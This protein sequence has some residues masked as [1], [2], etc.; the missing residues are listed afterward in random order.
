MTPDGRRKPLQDVRHNSTDLLAYEIVAFRRMQ[1][2]A[3][4]WQVPAISLTAQSF[5]LTTVFG[6]TSEV[7]RVVTGL[8]SAVV[9]AISVQLMA[10]HRRHEEID[11]RWLEAFERSQLMPTIHERPRSRAHD[12]G[13]PEE[14]RFTALRSFHVWVGGLASFGIVALVA[15]GVAAFR[16]VT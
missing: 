13:M 3:L 6:A 16:V 7:S 5:L 10:K 11:S 9:A 8:L 2:D 12:L 4:M 14:N 1:Y 15:A